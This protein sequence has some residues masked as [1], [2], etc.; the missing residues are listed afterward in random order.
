[1][2][3]IFLYHRKLRK[4]SNARTVGAGRS[5]AGVEQMQDDVG[6]ADF[7]PGALD[8]EELDLV[9]RVVDGAGAGGVDDV[10]RDAFDLDGL[11][12]LVAGGAGD[13]A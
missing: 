13:S 11:A 12:D 5:V 8:A 7:A 4:N 9:D 3:F 10:Q 1:M 2:R 6:L